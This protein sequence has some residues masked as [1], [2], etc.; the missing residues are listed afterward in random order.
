M[1]SRNAKPCCKGCGHPISFHGSDKRPKKCKV[2]SCACVGYTGV[3]SIHVDTISVAQAA[4]II[5]MSKQYVID[6]ANEYGGK[7]IS[8]RASKGQV[9]SEKMWRFDYDKMFESKESGS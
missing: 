4:R 7:L 1:P 3:L 8:V 6:H 2:G 9:S 5:N